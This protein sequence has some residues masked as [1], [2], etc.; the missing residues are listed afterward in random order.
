MSFTYYVAINDIANP[1]CL[2]EADPTPVCALLKRNDTAP[3]SHFGPTPPFF[4]VCASSQTAMVLGFFAHK[5]SVQTLVRIKATGLLGNGPPH[6]HIMGGFWKLSVAHITDLVLDKAIC[7]DYA[8][9]EMSLSYTGAAKTPAQLYSQARIVGLKKRKI[10]L[11]ADIANLKR[12][13]AVRESEVQAH[14]RELNEA[15]TQNS[16]GN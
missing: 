1:R 5:L 7:L 9:Y 2:Q 13:I 6:C 4:A 12:R 8:K 3:V 10:E 15:M 14:D 16:E 11:Q